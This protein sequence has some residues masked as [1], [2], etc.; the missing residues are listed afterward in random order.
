MQVTRIELPPPPE[1]V[2]ACLRR[3]AAAGGRA[4]V[5]GGAV[6]D[7][8]QSRVP[9]D[10]DLA[11]DLEPA[12]VAAVLPDAD[13]GEAALGACR[14]TIDG[15]PLTVTTLR[16]ESGYRDQRHPDEVVFVREVA[17][18]ALRRDF[19]VNAL[20]FD[21]GTAELTD[22][23]GGV[24]DLRAGVLRC[25]G[26][27]EQRFA[28]DA[29]RLL[30]LVRFAASADLQ[31]EAQ[32]AAAA[33]AAAAGLRALS[34]E[35]VYGELTRMFTGRGRGRALRLLVDLGLAAVVL[36]E[37]AAMD[38]VEQPPEYHP[39]GDVLTHVCMVLDHCPEGDEVLAWSAVLHDV[40]KPPTFRVA[41][42]RIRFDGH[43]TLSARMAEEVLL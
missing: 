43:D 4:W 2:T 37:C 22:P 34:A 10:F 31:I 3:L 25:I 15:M 11:T 35:R 42:D 41:E 23:C 26:D 5:V 39:E 27:P 30:R 17:T 24:A 9:G 18:D 36:P 16:A 38:G 29:L 19:T 13:L 6:R 33:Q 8:L 12:A 7:L 32:T 1:P 20:Y 21:P 40:G 14:V 28:Q